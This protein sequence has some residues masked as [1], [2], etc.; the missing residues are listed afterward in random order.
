MATRTVV[1]T[2]DTVN[3]SEPKMGG[4]GKNMPWV[5]V[6]SPLK[7]TSLSS[8]TTLEMARSI[9]LDATI[10]GKTMSDMV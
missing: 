7:R 3:E 10:H 2:Q 6:H 5:E 9:M 1:R 8:H 4:G